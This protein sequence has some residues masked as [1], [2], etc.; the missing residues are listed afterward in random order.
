MQRE[1]RFPSG[2]LVILSNIAVM[3]YCS[4]ISAAILLAASAAALADS[5]RVEFNRDVRPI[6]SDT[7]FKCH[8]RDANARQADLRFDVREVAIKPREND[9]GK[10]YTPIVPGDPARSEAWRRITSNNPDDLMPPPDSHLVLTDK[11]KATIKRWIEQGAEYEPHWA[12]LPVKPPP[13]PQPARKNWAHNE[14]DAFVLSR[15]ESEGLAPAPEADKRSLIRRVTL[16]LTGLPPTPAEVDAF[17]NDASPNA[18]ERVVDRLL[19]SPNYGERMAL[20]WLDAARYADTHGFNNDSLRSMWRWRDWVI[21]SFNANKPYDDFLTEQLAGDLIANA[22]LDQKIAS[23][24]NRNHVINSEVGIIDEEYRVEYVADRASTAGTVFMGLTLQCARCHDHKYD[25]LTQKEF[26][27]LFAFFNSIDEKGY[28]PAT[29]DGEPMIKAPTKAQQAELAALASEIAPL[30]QARQTRLALAEQTRAQW[31]PRLREATSKPV[32]TTQGLAVHLPL[33]EG[34]TD[35]I[36]VI[37]AARPG[38]KGILRGKR[39]AAKGKLE[40]ALRLDG[41]TTIDLGANVGNFGGSDKFSFGA[42][43]N[44]SG[45]EAGTI[46]ARMDDGAAHRGYDL[47]ISKGVLEA[48]VINT[49][50]AK[51]ARVEAKKPLAAGEWHH[52]FVTYDGSGKAAGLKLYANGELLEATIT[53]DTLGSE[54]YATKVPLLVGRRSAGLPFKGAIDDVRV[55]SRELNAAEVR[56]V[57]GIDAIGELL[58]IAADK[59]THAQQDTLAEH[60][61]KTTDAEYRALLTK[62]DETKQREAKLIAAVPTVMV[63]QEMSPPRATFVLKRGAYNAP[64]EKVSPGVP[65]ALPP[66]PTSAPPNRLGLAMWLTDPTHPLTSRVAVNR[67]WYQYFGVGLV[68]TMEDWGVQGEMPSHPELLDWLASRFMTGPALSERSESKGWDVKALQK[69]IVTSA[70]YRQAARYTPEQIER[71]PENRLLSRG[72]R[73]RLSAEAIRDN[74]LALSGLLVDKLGG[75]SVMPYQ[76]PGLWEDVVVGADYPGTK[77]VQARGEDLYRRSMYTFWKRTAPP[78]TLNTFDA[79]EREFCQIRRP[80]T[81]TPLQALALLNDPTYLEASR[82]L[83]E[84]MM[85]DAPPDA[86][87]DDRLTWAFRLATAH[88]PAPEELKVLR[89]TFDRRLA[90]FNKSPDTAKKLLAIGESPRDPKLNEPELAAYTTV[91]SMLLNLDEVITK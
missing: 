41:A 55:Y 40:G 36:E 28:I 49:W 2:S 17:V 73:L 31:E 83:A 62:L 38:Y 45:A 69:L 20:D 67:F 42:W 77:Y 18:Y 60:H 33:D 4:I 44:P 58:A 12:F 57:S 61:L 23:A 47:L 74:A 16:D 78:P 91:A 14:I 84:R 48:H 15:L 43:I 53:N 82:K 37:D 54:D 50:P 80:Q 30:A 7:C 85:R 56:A 89:E 71:D 9:D 29:G 21:E 81:N 10:P 68:K 87:I 88:A 19:A 8:G 64:D 59:R 76:P 72:P 46:I 90:A 24:F 35:S 5:A 27:Q 75:P 26:Y 79:P 52:V 34:A 39:I 25:P 65:A 22:T 70:T 13:L 11:Q 6:L 86:T 66:M 1:L 63:M 32:P 3:R 51:G